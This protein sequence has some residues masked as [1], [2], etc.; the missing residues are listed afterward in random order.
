MIINSIN[1]TATHEVIMNS[2]DLNVNIKHDN[3][4]LVILLFV[5]MF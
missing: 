3:P 4:H 2:T 5:A 1:V